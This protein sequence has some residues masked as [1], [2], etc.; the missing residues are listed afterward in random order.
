M[1]KS[2]PRRS[3]EEPGGW[4]SAGDIILAPL[5]GMQKEREGPEG[6]NWLYQEKEARS[7]AALGVGGV[8][9]IWFILSLVSSKCPVDEL[10][11]GT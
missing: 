2:S 4:E 6:Q 1:H 5:Q 10:K 9:C 8:C 11:R 3:T 7:A